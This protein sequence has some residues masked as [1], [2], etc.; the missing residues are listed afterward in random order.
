MFCHSHCGSAQPPGH[1]SPVP[2][3]EPP[4]L[5]TVLAECH[6]M[7]DVFSKVKALSLPPH[8]PYNRAIDLVPRASLPSSRLYQLS[9]PEKQAMEN[10]IQNSLAAG[11]IQPSSSSVGAGLLFVEKKDKSLRLCID[12][13]GL[14][15]ITVK[16]KYPLP[17]IDS[18]F[19]SLH[20]AK[21]C[22][23]RYAKQV[24]PNLPR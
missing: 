20:R 15:D 9:K 7:A 6:D 5:S 8:H 21:I 10:S 4:D 14:N 24:R 22:P 16:N 17:L 2:P 1:R 11:L 3:P 19:V 13:R 23:L 12:D 18:T